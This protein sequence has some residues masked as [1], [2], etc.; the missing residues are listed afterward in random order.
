MRA[1]YDGLRTGQ[2]DC[3]S[4]FALSKAIFARLGI[5]TMDIKRTEG[6][7]IQSHYWNYV[8]IGTADAAK[9]YHFDACPIKGEHPRFGFLLTD[10][11]VNDYTASRT[12][13]EDGKTV[14]NFFYAYD[15]A[16]YPKSATEIINPNV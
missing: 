6:I 16:R 14:S 13:E 12:M 15:A 9:W 7:S 3:F 8:N 11:Q 5:E 1:A 4:Y 10:E 2:G